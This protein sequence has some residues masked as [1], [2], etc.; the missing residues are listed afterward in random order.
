MTQKLYLDRLRGL[1]QFRF[2]QP[3]DADLGFNAYTDLPGIV[4]SHMNKLLNAINYSLP[5]YKDKLTIAHL[6]ELASR[7]KKELNPINGNSTTEFQK[8]Y[9]LQNLE[10]VTPPPNVKFKSCWEDD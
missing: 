1:L 8:K 5:Y 2:E 10:E 7:I 4:K 3:L 6:T 9:S